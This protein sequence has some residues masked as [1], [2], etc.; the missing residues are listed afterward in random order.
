MF[1]PLRQKSKIAELRIFANEQAIRLGVTWWGVLVSPA[2]SAIIPS[3]GGG[4][5]IPNTAY[6]ASNSSVMS[7]TAAPM[8]MVVGSPNRVSMNSATTGHCGSSG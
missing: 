1:W 2:I 3:R 6:T 5:H 4:F 7:S 8:A